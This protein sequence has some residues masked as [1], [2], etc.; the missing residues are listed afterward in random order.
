MTIDRAILLRDTEYFAGELIRRLE[1]LQRHEPTPPV[2]STWQ[3]SAALTRRIRVELRKAS[4]RERLRR[5]REERL[6]ES[7]R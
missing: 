7:R 6:Q 3:Q 1:R 5:L 4:A 2:R